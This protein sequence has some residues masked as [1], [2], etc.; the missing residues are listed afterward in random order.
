MTEFP[1]L[2]CCVFGNIDALS[3]GSI[4]WDRHRF[5]RRARAPEDFRTD[6]AV[7]VAG[8]VFLPVVLV[9]AMRSFRERSP[10]DCRLRVVRLAATASLICALVA[11]LARGPAVASL[12]RLAPTFGLVHHFLAAEFSNSWLWF[13]A[14]LVLVEFNPY[15][16]ATMLVLLALAVVI[17]A[18]KRQRRYSSSLLVLIASL[19]MVI[20]PAADRV[21]SDTGVL[22]SALGVPLLLATNRACR[23]TRG[24]VIAPVLFL[25]AWTIHVCFTL[26]PL[27]H[28]HNATDVWCRLTTPEAFA[29]ATG[30]A[31]MSPGSGSMAWREGDP[32]MPLRRCADETERVLSLFSTVFTNVAGFF[33]IDGALRGGDKYGATWGAATVATSCFYHLLDVC[34]S[35]IFGI[36]EGSFHRL[37]D[38]CAIS[39]LCGTFLRWISATNETKRRYVVAVVVL[40]EF[41]PW[42]TFYS[43]VPIFFSA[44]HA[45]YHRRRV[46]VDRRRK[47]GAVLYVVALGFF[48]KGLDE[49]ND[50]HRMFHGAWHVWGGA[51]MYAWNVDDPTRL[52]R[53]R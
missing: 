53:R 47:I 42:N 2:Q 6:P 32:T 38:M 12:S 44:L 11:N 40:K 29:R 17:E 52:A 28:Q 48:F 36:T 18:A 14:V 5:A 1:P 37:D 46:Y 30:E 39:V 22:M 43:V 4:L 45:L 10:R 21:R 33:S 23:G 25:S 24:R 8:L 7:L 49:D 34:E 27:E 50:P 26:I 13:V 15:S 31:C 19:L 20:L 41:W 51:A 35:T 16:F 9:D 3:D